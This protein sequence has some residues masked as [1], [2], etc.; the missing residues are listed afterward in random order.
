MIAADNGSMAAGGNIN[1]DL[2]LTRAERIHL[3]SPESRVPIERVEAGPVL[4]NV[5]DPGLFV[6]HSA[7]LDDLDRVLAPCGEAVVHVVHGLGGVGKSALVAHWDRARSSHGPKRWINADSPAAID[8]GLAAF[9]VGLQP[10][11]AGADT[12][13]LRDRAGRR[14]ACHPN[15]S[16]RDDAFSADVRIARTRTT[17]TTGGPPATMDG[18]GSMPGCPTPRRRAH[19]I[20]ATRPRREHH[21]RNPRRAGR[22]A[23]CPGTVTDPRTTCSFHA[24]V[25]GPTGGSDP[26]SASAAGQAFP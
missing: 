15:D 18:G 8:A 2:G 7:V 22:L 24:A 3:F 21:R 5:P 20:K 13:F 17:P 4:D 16:D 11:L 26:P 6:G 10:T 19:R 9:A 14:P 23:K 12:D 25:S 1:A